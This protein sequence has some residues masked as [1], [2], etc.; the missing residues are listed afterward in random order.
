MITIEVPTNGQGFTHIT[1]QVNAVLT[2][3]AKLCHVFVQH[4]SCSLLIQENADASVQRDLQKF[5]AALA[6]HH[7]FEHDDEGPDDMPAHAKAAILRTSELIPVANG[8]LA[9]GTWQGL[10]LVEHRHAPHTRKLV[11]TLL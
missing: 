6:D 2:D 4:T 9:L 1:Q 5:F 3:G 7:D 10:Y 8:K 11:V